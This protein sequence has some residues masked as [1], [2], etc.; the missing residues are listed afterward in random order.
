MRHALKLA[1]AGCLAAGLTGCDADRD[2]VVTADNDAAP[3]EPLPGAFDG[4]YIY[5]TGLVQST[6]PTSFVLDYGS[7]TIIVE[8]DDWDAFGEGVVVNPGDRVTVS[9]R[10]DAD[11]ATGKTIEAGSVY[12]HSLGTTFFASADDEETAVP[13]TTLTFNPRNVDLTGRVFAISGR[14]ITLGAPTGFLRVDTAG[15]RDNPLDDQGNR[16]IGVGD[17]VYVWGDLRFAGPQTRLIAEGI[18]SLTP[19]PRRAT[20]ETAGAGNQTATDNA[21]TPANVQGNAAGDP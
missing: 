19:S 2:D 14:E 10:V 16:R 6:N 21:A 1:L 11:F 9:G 8:M 3:I 4:A 7:D 15:L 18:V 20:G 12:I 13:D 5:L 17:R